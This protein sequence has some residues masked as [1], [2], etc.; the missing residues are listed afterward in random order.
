MICNTIKN[1]LLLFWVLIYAVSCEDKIEL[2]QVQTVVLY[3]TLFTSFHSTGNVVSDGG[4]TISAKGFCWST[5]PN[6]TI[7]ND[8]VVVNSGDA[9]FSAKI[10]G[11]K[12]NTKYYVRAY[13]T[14]SLGTAYGTQLQITTRGKVKDI[15]GNT[16]PVI[17][18][19]NQTWMSS[20]LKVTR[21]RDGTPIKYVA[22]GW[23]WGSQNDASYCWYNNDS[24]SYKANYGAMYNWYAANSPLL[25]PEGW[26][27][28]GNNDW[29][30]LISTLGGVEV[31]GGKLKETGTIHWNAPN[32]DAT[33]ESGFSALPGGY[34]S[35]VNGAYFS[36]RDNAGWWTT[37]AL[38]N[39]L[40]LSYHITL[41]TTGF[42][43][44]VE[45]NK[46]YG[47]SIRC[48]LIEE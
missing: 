35:Y 37:T 31:A 46:N 19:G 5:T 28:P 25:C 43:R 11:L 41:Y 26:K 29:S 15:D 34:R 48:I 23:E 33:N 12:A 21:F 9:L 39:E 4:N 45:N 22:S 38:N 8:T 36:I 7:S 20:N 24:T 44:I 17:T 16:Y 10:K 3:D 6:P 14:N 40:A 30:K 47:L 1:A 13:S 27:V 18:I 32:A 42:V 2:P